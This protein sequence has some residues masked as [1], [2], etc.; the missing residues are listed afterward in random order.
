MDRTTATALVLVNWRGV[1]YERYL[2]DENVTA[3]EGANG[4]GKTTVMIAAYVVLLPDLTRLRFTNLGESGATGGDRG[5]WGRL[6]ELGRPSYSAL[7]LRLADGERIVLGVHLERKAEPALELTP[8]LVRSLP[9]SVPLQRLLLRQ[10][11]GYDEVP[12]LEQLQQSATAHDA[13]LV[14]CTSLKDYFSRLFELGVTPMRLT[15][16]EDRNKWNDMLRTSMTGGISRALT[17]QLR[18]FVFKQDT[19]LADTLGRMRANLS[20]CRRTRIEVS[21]ARV[22]EQEISGVYDAGVAMFSA[23]LLAARVRVRELQAELRAAERNQEQASERASELSSAAQE[24][25]VRRA[26]LTQRRQRAAGAMQVAAEHVRQVE[27]ALTASERLQQL[28]AQLQRA[29]RELEEKTQAQAQAVERRQSALRTRDEAQAAVARTA[30]GLADFQSGLDE[31][32]QRAHTYRLVT[33]RLE[34]AQQRLALSQLEAAELDEVILGVRERLRKLDNERIRRERESA[35]LTARR[36]EYESAKQA[37]AQLTQQPHGAAEAFTVARRELARLHASE[38]LAARVPELSR[39]RERVEQMARRQAELREELNRRGLEGVDGAAFLQH[40]QDLDRR[41]R[42]L[43]DEEREAAWQVRLLEQRQEELERERSRLEERQAQWQRVHEL[44]EA[45]EALLPQLSPDAVAL[46]EAHASLRAEFEAHQRQ[47]EELAEQRQQAW[48]HIAQLESGHDLHADPALLQLCDELEGE[49]LA[50]RFD[51]LDA[52]PARYVEAQLGPWMHAIVVE[53]LEAAKQRVDLRA[54]ELDTVWL[55]QAG[56]E[57]PIQMEALNELPRQVAVQTPWGSRLRRLPER[58]SLGQRARQAQLKEWRRRASSLEG[59]LEQASRRA[60][61]LGDA[62]RDLEQLERQAEVWRAGD[63]SARLRELTERLDEARSAQ[64]QERERAVGA[65]SQLAER[66]ASADDLRPLLA[67]AA[68]LD[69]PDYSQQLAELEREL[70]LAQASQRELDDLAQARRVLTESLEALRWEL[71]SDEELRRWAREHELAC[72]KR[73]E[74]CEVDQALT[75][76]RQHRDALQWH[77]VAEQLATHERLSPKL[78]ALHSE[79]LG[80][81]AAMQEAVT[82][83]D[84]AWEGATLAL[85]E[86]QAQLTALRA[87]QQRAE[88]ELLGEGISHPSQHSLALARAQLVEAERHATEVE[89]E[90]NTIAERAARADERCAQ[91][92]QQVEAAEREV[93]R[94]GELAAPAERE[95]EQLRAQAEREELLAAALDRTEAYDGWSSSQLRPEARSQA[96]LLID[97][98]AAARGG[99]SLAD[100]LERQWDVTFDAAECLRAWRIVRGWLTERVPARVAEARDP[101]LALSRLREDLRRLEGRLQRQEDDLKGHSRDVARNIEVQIRKATHRVRRLNQ[102]LN[103]VCFGSIAGVRIRMGRAER[104]GRVLEAL[105]DGSAQALLFQSSM[106]IEEALDEIFRRYGAGRGGGQR[107]L[108]Y[109]EYIELNVQIQRQQSDA[110]EGASASRLSTGEAIGVGAALMMVILTEWERDANLLRSK[111]CGGALRFLFLDEAN[112]LSQDNLGTLFELCENLQLQLLVAAPE[113]AHVDGNTTYRLVRRV[114]EDGVEEV[115]ASGRR[116]QLPEA[117]AA[118]EH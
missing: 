70:E 54:L 118:L 55:V 4:A 98:L 79:A 19:G 103:D 47:I 60:T 96:R 46:R 93:R 35:D 22:L 53:D 24:L 27:R 112:R 33:E 20:A 58:A 11:D 38:R 50:R 13:K 113:V 66:R 67:A 32:H 100:E 108:D 2:L 8:F 87:H 97:R 85:Q 89:L 9:E 106:P 14:V 99:A 26:T 105:R 42:E 69:G 116:K 107:L 77:E 73:D 51:E 65:R 68:L 16:D 74:L 41:C 90:A 1:F 18:E 37:L 75:F 59:E 110:W 25:A 39:E 43:Q 52:E 15:G 91:A 84:A 64:T 21:E 34:Q 104:S 115:I 28:E 48:E 94:L 83:A 56:C 95:W 92:R 86:A 29:Q 57:L 81:A 17:T 61:A 117:T 62:L 76:V 102:F 82:A 30:Q 6:G 88:Q 72:A 10:L 36:S 49:L 3:L 44:S 7:Q 101:L 80:R 114:N 63:P 12:T 45:L 71:P 40:V 23:A 109:R 111:R 31:L 78:S 5:I